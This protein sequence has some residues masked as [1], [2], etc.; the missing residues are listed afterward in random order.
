[1]NHTLS[2]ETEWY[3][4]P[5]TF[6]RLLRGFD[7]DPEEAGRRYEQLRTRLISFFDWQGSPSAEEQADETFN[8][9]AR[10]LVE[11]AETDSLERYAFGVARNL[12]RENWRRPERLATP[13]DE[14]PPA[15]HPAFDPV[16]REREE[17]TG[18][19]RETRLSYLRE[20]LSQLPPANREL[21]LRYYQGERQDKI[22]ARK[23]L[24]DQLAVAP[25]HLRIQAY[26]LRLKLEA[27]VQSRLGKI[28]SGL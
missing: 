12:L 20:C 2:E 22:R 8:R 19:E 4:T 11:G 26:R 1:M 5:E 21:V 3:L 18:L 6:A 28:R 27:C 14:L 15:Q 17:A 16:Q 24:A 23:E 25:G 7:P 9:V 10:R 13:L